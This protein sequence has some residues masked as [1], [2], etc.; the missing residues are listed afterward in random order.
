VNRDVLG[1]VPREL[2]LPDGLSSEED[3]LRVVVDLLDG[4]RAE[5]T[6]ARLKRASRSHQ[7]G[8]RWYG[9]RQVRSLLRDRK[10]HCQTMRDIV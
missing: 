10:W 4:R 6:F 5:V 7:R 2:S 8:P 3:R 9:L 1:T